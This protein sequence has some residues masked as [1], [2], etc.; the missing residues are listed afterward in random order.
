MSRS[1]FRRVYGERFEPFQGIPGPEPTFPVGNALDFVTGTPWEHCA[2]YART[3]GGLTL[4]WLGGAPALVLND[5]TLIGEVLVD[6]WQDFYK[7]APVEALAPVITKESLF[8]SNPPAWAPA[9]EKDPL[10]RAVSTSWL[11][12]Q[13]KPMQRVLL[14]RLQQLGAGPER[15]CDLYEDTQRLTFAAFSQ[16]FWGREFPPD[17]Y[18]W[19]Q[20]LAREGSLRM[21]PALPLFPPL[22]PWFHSARTSWYDSFQS[23]VTEA[24]RRPD[25]SAPDLLHASAKLGSDL[26]D[27]RLAE[28]LA[29]NFFGG[30]FSASSTINSALYLLTQHPEEARLL[31][32]ALEECCG[33]D[34]AWTAAALEGCRRL[35]FVVRESM[36]YYPAVPLYFRNSATDRSV[37]LG[38]REL[39]PNTLLFIS[40][41][42][43][44]RESDHWV[45]PELFSPDRWDHGA[46]EA[47]PLGSGY[48]F[49][50]GR[51]PRQC[52]GAPFAM[53]YIKL[54]LAVILTQSRV[55]IAPDQPYHQS[56]FFGVMMPKG[57]TATWT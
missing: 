14:S 55:T 40:N 13:V 1:I 5:P 47:N 36:R 16:A 31:R 6:R 45:K 49:P 56:F 25:P 19:F 34:R 44:H 46:A 11:S 8:I 10:G 48:F 2:E 21:N 4:I 15:T 23:L 57:L 26:P 43:L 37:R 33:P 17:R 52:I 53:L 51:G 18:D 35:D 9:R 38:D 32:T 7:N 41:W 20:A 29:T 24:R 28:A 27:E 50:F 54:A 42:W 39:P 12:D 30:V 22:N 3:Y